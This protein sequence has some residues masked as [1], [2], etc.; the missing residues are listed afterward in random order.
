MRRE[1]VRAWEEPVIIPTY[2][3]QAAEKLPMFLDKRVYQ[4]SSGKVY[5]NAFTDRVSDTAAEVTY[6]G[7]FLENEYIRVMI[8]PEIGG[9]IHIGYDKT[10]GY[11]FFY[12]QNVIKPALVGLL[13]PWISGGVEF[14][15]PQHH[16]PSTFMPL[17]YSIEEHE[18]GSCTVW[19]SELEPM[20]RMK[21]M[22]GISLQPGKSRIEA[23]VRLYNRTQFTQTF[24]WWA[25]VGVRV[26]EQYQSFFPPDVTYV[27]DHAKRA[28]SSFPI[29]RNYYYG[30]DYTKGVD[31]TWYKNV[32][33]PTSYMVTKSDFN[34]FGGYDHAREAGFV[35]VANRFIAPGKKQW[36]WGNAEFGQAWDR[37]LTDSDGP[38]IEL[39][40]G[41]YTDNQPDFSF[42]AP[43]ETRTFSQFWY[44]IQGIGPAKNANE[45]LAI[46]LEQTPEGW[47][48]GVSVSEWLDHL[49][50]Q[51]IGSGRILVERRVNVRPGDPFV[52]TMDVDDTELCLKVLD[53]HARELIRYA[54]QN[55]QADT[56]P[57]PAKEP[58]P[59]GEIRTNEELYL[60]GLHLEQY[61]HATRAPQPYWSEALSR[62]A[63]DARCN[64]ALGLWRLRQGC[65]REAETHFRTA[66]ERLTLL[67][68]NP[69]DGEAFYGLGHA[70]RF[71]G[72]ID[73]AYASFYKAGWNYAW[74][75][76]AYYELAAID[77]GCG[78]YVAAL[79]HLELSLT[80][81]AGHLKARNLQV[82]IL[83]RLGRRTE[84][85]DIVSGTV[86]FDPLDL[87][88]RH[89]ASLLS[90][91]DARKVFRLFRGAVQTYL[92]VAF[93]YAH[94]GLWK[95][96]E[97]LLASYV[98][99]SGSKDLYPM[100]WYAR[101]Y[102]EN[103][104]GYFEQAADSYR[105]AKNASADYC[106]PSRLEELLMLEAALHHDPH[107]ARAHLY[108]GNLLY[109]KKHKHEAITHWEAAANLE[110]NSPIAWRN[111]GIAYFN[112]H[113]DT[114]SAIRSYQNARHADPS[115]PRLLYE[116][117]QLRKRSGAS[118]LER[119]GELEKY[120]DLVMRRDDLTVELIT[121]YNQLGQHKRALSLITQRRF[122]PWEG[123]EGAV[124]GQYVIAHLQ[125][126][127]KA[128]DRGEPALA[129]SH[130]DTARKY[131]QDLGEGKHLLTQEGH[132]DCF[133]GVA[134]EQLGRHEEAVS[135]WRKAAQPDERIDMFA[136]YRG[137]ALR[138]LGEEHTASRVF[139]KL[140]EHAEALA[141]TEAKIDYFATSLPNFLLFEDDLQ[142]RQLMEALFLQGLAR[143]GLGR[144][145]E[146]L[147]NL[148]KVLELDK[149]HWWASFELSRA[150]MT[151]QPVV[152]R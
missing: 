124:S 5:P 146:A 71:Q 89:E 110:P 33:V 132:L 18:D 20:N 93:D 75:S 149:N 62:D 127:L 70:L 61:R 53:E 88:S 15:W 115:D 137:V 94:G 48:V 145:E 29:A 25:N 77:C 95:D 133:T 134:L 8:L 12:R 51:V 52:E 50:V 139:Q 105:K 80:T 14:N 140:L 1:A 131:P 98:A 104:L 102:F 9:R 123:G 142:K 114:G 113:G 106:F 143:L 69:A 23:K 27:A 150:R 76:A 109:D 2:R 10:N 22:V 100:F 26:H 57:I 39:M 17:E 16:R 41:V 19:L 44:P 24:L 56:L 144:M 47:K 147:A 4:G 120:A 63:G 128:L 101:A 11:D 55:S 85:L 117:D 3:A 66:I 32:P 30:V 64:V 21:G 107:D 116:F 111:L 92:D 87:F 34:F 46:N 97:D 42:L 136:Y 130:F 38:Y 135:M 112:V 138:S 31:L 67:N 36:T 58:L 83:R 35:H 79:S 151:N 59:P 73:E 68:P 103:R 126:G 49:T 108:L 28:M 13:G 86:K 148:E 72:K 90:G 74:Q 82:A 81:N 121:L 60:T 96:A 6:R 152:R 40:A 141:K 119:I 45:R 7:V 65:F 37:E 125:L 78:N 54:P 99:N 129:L 118:P 122:H 43:Y 91:K 84:A